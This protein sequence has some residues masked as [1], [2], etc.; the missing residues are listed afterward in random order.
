VNT[1]SC[2]TQSILPLRFASAGLRFWLLLVS[3]TDFWILQR[4][5]QSL[6][7]EP[8]I[9]PSAE[10]SVLGIDVDAICAYSLGVAS[11]L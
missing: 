3:I 11:I 4:P 6:T 1:F 7:R 8:Y 10:V 5:P 2:L 9:V